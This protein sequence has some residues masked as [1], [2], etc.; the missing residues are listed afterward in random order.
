MVEVSAPNTGSL[1]DIPRR[2]LGIFPTPLI[3][4]KRLTAAL[5]GPRILIKRDDMSGF[6]YGGNKVRALEYHLAEAVAQKADVLVTAGGEQSNHVR[7][8]AASARIAGLQFVAV[9]HGSPPAEIQGN[10]LLDKLLGAEIRFTGSPDRALVDVKIV[11][12]AD[13]LRQSGRRPYVIPRGGATALGALGYVECVREMVNQLADMDLRPDWIVLATGSCSTQAGLLAGVKLCNAPYRVFGITVSRP[14]AECNERIGHLAREA[15]ELAG[16]PM[17]ISPDEIK[18]SD[19]FIGTGY[20]IPTP[21]GIEA[22]RLVAGTEG[23]FLDPTY[24]G[25]AMAGLIDASRSGRIGKEETVVF[26]HTGGE[27]GLFAHPE[28]ADSHI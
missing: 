27:P 5:G 7:V 24:T 17:A 13:A 28:V 20:G 1:A 11:E 22:I 10:L 16:R 8:T 15:L 21:E 19:E 6:A 12:V 9:L 14:L 26:I 2:P 3:E 23:L 4:A 18:V 25:K